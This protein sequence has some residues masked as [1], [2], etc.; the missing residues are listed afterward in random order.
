MKWE[1]D[2]KYKV[3]T[4]CNNYYIRFENFRENKVS[5]DNGFHHLAEKEWVDMNDLL[6]AFLAGYE[7]ANIKPTKQFYL[8]WLAACHKKAQAK[9]YG[10]I[11]DLYQEKFLSNDNLI[12]KYFYKLSDFCSLEEMY[13]ALASGEKPSRKDKA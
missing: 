13:E 5:K 11:W 7:V 2:E 10:K 3:I 8:N 1:I 12:D 6:D 9:A 4:L